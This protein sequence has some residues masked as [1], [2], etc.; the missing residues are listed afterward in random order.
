MVYTRRGPGE[1]PP[2]VSG[3]P[4]V[5]EAASHIVSIARRAAR[6]IRLARGAAGLAVGAA[7]GGAVAAGA[8]GAAL[9]GWATADIWPIIAAVWAGCAVVGAAAGLARRCSPAEAALHVDLAR[10]LKQRFATAVELAPPP[11]AD[12][13]AARTCFAQALAALGHRPLAGVRVWRRAHRPLA[14]AALAAILAAALGMLLA[15]RRPLGRM[16][17]PRREALA[18]AFDRQASVVGAAEI[19]D[20]LQAASAAVERV[21]D[22]HLAQLLDDLR[23]QGFE[24]VDLTPEAVRAAAALLPPG[25]SAAPGEPTPGDQTKP[26]V[27]DGPAEGIDR[28]VRIY[29]PADRSAAGNGSEDELPP[30]EASYD[31]AWSA[32]RL[33]AAQS[34]R[35]GRIPSRYR[36]IVRRYFSADQ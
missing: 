10:G 23:E 22:E 6:R 32:A 18:R 20:A 16:S 35:Q 8:L 27:A 15:E 14:A 25:P 29:D 4:T 33:R 12:E 21:D 5:N 3:E 13:P 2:G 7:A 11:R 17:A 24:P 36:A 34:L 28:W 1:I 30:A 26:T 19:R 9:L 31:Q